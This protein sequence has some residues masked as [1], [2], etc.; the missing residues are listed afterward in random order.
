MMLAMRWPRVVSIL[1]LMVGAALVTPSALADEQL[2]RSDPAAG[3]HLPSAPTQVRLHLADGYAVE[4]V[5]VV[6]EDGADWA[7]A[8]PVEEDGGKVSVELDPEM[9]A[10]AYK[11]RWAAASDGG[12]RVGGVVTFSIAPPPIP[13]PTLA[14]P[15][16]AAL[17][18]A[19]TSGPGSPPWVRTLVGSALGVVV[20]LLVLP[21][22]A[23]W[24]TRRIRAADPVEQALRASGAMELGGD[25]AAP[26]ER[27]DRGAP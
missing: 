15:D 13:M 5:A 19:Q 17:E 6:G 11:I 21:R 18:L 2:V 12:E 3:A 9:P 25:D 7:A 16:P 26:D 4:E 1:L 24:R 27:A 10:G 23:R 8:P 14:Q 20:S 22:V